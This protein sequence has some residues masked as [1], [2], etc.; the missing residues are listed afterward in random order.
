MIFQLEIV[1]KPSLLFEMDRL[2]FFLKLKNIG[3]KFPKLLVQGV[4]RAERFS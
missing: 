2:S 3:R 1:V 4:S